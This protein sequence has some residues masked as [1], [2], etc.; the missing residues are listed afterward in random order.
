[1]V[2]LHQFC[3]LIVITYTY[4]ASISK[5]YAQV[6]LRTLRIFG[7]NAKTTQKQLM[8][9]IQK[10]A[11]A[12]AVTLVTAEEADL[13][14]GSSSNSGQANEND[15]TKEKKSAWPFGGMARVV[16]ASVKDANKVM[17]AFNRKSIH[18]HV[19]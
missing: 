7:L 19:R 4:E 10:V 14:Y 1:M 17:K 18:D 8:K 11:V 6:S 9:R 3:F 15:D 5:P 13:L 2:L 16:L 12:E